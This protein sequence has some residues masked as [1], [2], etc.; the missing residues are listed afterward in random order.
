MHVLPICRIR[1]RP[2]LARRCDT[3]AHHAESSHAW[4]H[5]AFTMRPTIPDLGYKCLKEQDLLPGKPSTPCSHP[6]L[7]SLRFYSSKM[8]CPCAPALC[9]SSKTAA[10]APSSP[11]P[12]ARLANS[13]PPPIPGSVFSTST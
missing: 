9:N 2:T 6:N 3:L 13:S 7:L 5:V 10:T 12:S 8:I 1:H 4:C 11:P